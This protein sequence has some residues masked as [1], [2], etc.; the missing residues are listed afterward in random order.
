MYESSRACV[1]DDETLEKEE[2]RRCEAKMSLYGG[3]VFVYSSS[4]TVRGGFL[5]DNAEDLRRT[6]KS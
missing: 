2:E 5:G 3:G 4:S 1:D 6:G